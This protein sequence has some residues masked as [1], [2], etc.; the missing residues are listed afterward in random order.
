MFQH[1]DSSKA[2]LNSLDCITEQENR[3]A[4]DDEVLPLLH[5]VNA[6]SSSPS[7][8]TYFPLAS[9]THTSLT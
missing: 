9:R 8:L 5:D 2:T 7:L 3:R 6:A 4:E 1:A